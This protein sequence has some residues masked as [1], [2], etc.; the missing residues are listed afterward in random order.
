MDKI[1]HNRHNL[2][3][4]EIS[5]GDMFKTSLLKKLLNNK[6][7]TEEIPE[8]LLDHIIHEDGSHTF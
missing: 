6:T 8:C 2:I 1:Q 7:S 4:Q 5:D 3:V